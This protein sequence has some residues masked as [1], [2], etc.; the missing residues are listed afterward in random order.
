MQTRRN[1]LA[2]ATGA[3][4][5][6]AGVARAAG[7]EVSASPPARPAAPHDVGRK[8][9]ADGRVRPFAGNTIICH[10]PQQGPGYET[11]DA[12]LDVYREMPIHEFGRK[13]ALLPPSSYHMTIFGGANDQGRSPGAWPAD[14]PTD[15]PIDVCSALL[16]KRLADFDLDCALPIRMRVNDAEPMH[17]EPLL[18]DLVPVDAAEN[19]KL[20]RL[21][22]RLS[23]TL[24]IRTRDHDRYGFHIT[25]AYQ[26][27]WF[28]EAENADFQRARDRWRSELRKTAPV[29]EFQAPEF[30]TFKDMFA[31]KSQFPLG[32]RAPA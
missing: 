9:F 21:R 11:F 8:F 30:C 3:L 22:D 18:I 17:P 1:L 7:A 13:I 14:I 28:D 31:F 12:L 16:A 25:L 32:R 20:R 26:I 27:A 19:L 29:I 4:L 24:K 2:A 15:T 10:L 5:G 6:A 23:Q